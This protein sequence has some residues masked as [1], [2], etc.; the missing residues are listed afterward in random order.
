M[1]QMGN[2]TDRNFALIDNMQ[3]IASAIKEPSLKWPNGVRNWC[4]FFDFSATKI[5]FCCQDIA[6]AN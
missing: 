4:L 1:I 6:I 5:T 2:V 3:N